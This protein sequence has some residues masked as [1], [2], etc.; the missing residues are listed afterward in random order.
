MRYQYCRHAVNPKFRVYSHILPYYKGA[1]L[2]IHDNAIVLTVRKH[3][4]T[5]ALVAV[6]T[7]THGVYKGAV[8]GAFSK[9]NR[10]LYQPGNHVAMHWSARLS[11]QMGSIKAEM[12]KPYSALIMPHAGALSLLSSACTLLATALP[13]RHV[14]QNLYKALM[15]LLTHLTYAPEE[16][17]AE[18]LRFELLLLAETGFGLDLTS[19]A[20]TG[21]RKELVYV[22][23]KSGRAVCAEAGKPYHDKMLPLPAFLLREKNEV[24]TSEEIAQGLRLTSYFLEHWL[25]EALHRKLPPART[26]LSSAA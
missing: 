25:F 18:Y 10:G 8:R 23:P 21:T 11:D 16:C 26:R 20:A 13:E 4:E 7:E 17:M 19:C 2:N 22:S 15:H 1:M 3:A 12:I 14:Y 9:N 5:S 24:P 6:F